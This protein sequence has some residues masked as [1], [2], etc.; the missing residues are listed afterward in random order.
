MGIEKD[1]KQTKPF[2][3][4]W[5]KA[6]VNIFYTNNWLMDRVKQE[7]EPYGITVQQYNVLRILRGAGKPISTAQIRE[8][9]IDKMSDTP[10]M[11]QRLY[12]KGLVEKTI[13]ASDKRLVDIILSKEGE[14]VLKRI[15]QLNEQMDGYMSNGLNEE[16][17][18]AL[19]KLL[20]KIRNKDS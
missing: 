11:V 10:R 19:S 5:H 14:K 9:L 20:D 3:N 4:P 13:C 8:S 15:D 7:L 16:D 17:A 6:M 2:R 1:I 12:K 18:E